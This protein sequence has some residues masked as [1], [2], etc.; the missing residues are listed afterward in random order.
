MTVQRDTVPPEWRRVIGILMGYVGTGKTSQIVRAFPK[1][2]YLKSDPTA[3]DAILDVIKNQP[4]IAKEMG[5][6][7][8]PTVHY[9]LINDNATDWIEWLTLFVKWVNHTMAQRHKK[10]K[11]MT[12]ADRKKHRKRLMSLA[13]KHAKLGI[14]IPEPGV[15][16]FVITDATTLWANTMAGGKVNHG[17]GWDTNDL[18]NNVLSFMISVFYKWNLGLMLDGHVVAAMEDKGYPRGFG[19]PLG[20][21]REGVAKE[22]TIVWE[23]VY[24]APE[25]DGLGASRYILTQ[26]GFSPDNP[27]G[28]IRKTRRYGLP[29]KLDLEEKSMAD[30]LCQVHLRLD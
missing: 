29:G 21:M 15:P 30:Y 20:R 18:V 24:E 23:L 6:S 4:E 12:P 13:G 10:L 27:M 28:T 22:M 9:N 11:A 16:G 25:D 3:L 5:L 17:S 2:G 7:E 14:D 1:W 19:W 8:T 26:P